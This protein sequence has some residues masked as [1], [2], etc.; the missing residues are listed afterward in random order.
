MPIADFVL[1]DPA[2]DIRG[3]VH[4]AGIV[5]GWADV[6]A[7]LVLS[8]GLDLPGYTGQELITLWRPSELI[9][10]GKRGIPFA[11]TAVNLAQVL[12]AQVGTA[13]QGFTVRDARE[14]DITVPVGAKVRYRVGSAAE[15]ASRTAADS[16]SVLITG[17][18]SAVEVP[19][20]KGDV[21]H[22][23]ADS[24]QSTVVAAALRFTLFH[25]D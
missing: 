2:T 14:V 25:Q 15:R 11:K 10:T 1:R 4:P 23:V 8:M 13:S 7:D 21:L 24:T 12:S 6:N 16:L 5:K 22:L 20:A 19:L 17:S 3:N 9:P 18:G